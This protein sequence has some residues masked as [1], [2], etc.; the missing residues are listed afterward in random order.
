MVNLFLVPCIIT[1]QPCRKSVV[2][3]VLVELRSYALSG[4][5]FHFAILCLATIIR[6][7]FKHIVF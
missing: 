4:I 1:A 7:Y 3:P 5:L 6:G 2:T